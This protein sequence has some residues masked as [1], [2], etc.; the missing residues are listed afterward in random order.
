MM[1]GIPQNS[2]KVNLLVKGLGFTAATR[3]LPAAGETPGVAK[4][5]GQSADK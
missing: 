4:E 2:V 1:R 3:M 5:S